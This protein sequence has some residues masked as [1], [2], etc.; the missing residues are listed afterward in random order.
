MNTIE[1]VNAANSLSLNN[2]KLYFNAISS[3][4][5][6]LWNIEHNKD[7]LILI[8][9]TRYIRLL[10]VMFNKQI[11]IVIIQYHIIFNTN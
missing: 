11:K 2:Y 9:D 3:M 5:I 10:Y 4:I 1:Y 6:E 8:C 7:P